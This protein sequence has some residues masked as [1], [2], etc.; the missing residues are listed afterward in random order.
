MVAK[1]L[2]QLPAAPGTKHDLP[3]IYGDWDSLDRHDINHT[4]DSFNK[5][6][7]EAEDELRQQTGVQCTQPVI[8]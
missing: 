2:R 4:L 5:M 8:V 1:Q 3:C 6:L 7:R